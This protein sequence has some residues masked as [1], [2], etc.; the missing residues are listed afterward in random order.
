MVVGGY[1]IDLYFPQVNMGVECE[2]AYHK[3]QQAKDRARELDLID[4]LNA[5][6]P[7]YG[8]RVLRVDVSRGYMRTWSRR[9]G[10]PWGL[11]AP[12][13]LAAGLLASWSPG[14]RSERPRSFREAADISVADGV[15][16]ATIREACNTL[17]STG[18]EHDLRRCYFTPR[19]Q[20]REEYGD[21]YR[22]WFPAKVTPEGRG[23]GG[24]LNLVSLDGSELFE[25][26][27][28]RDYV[29]DGDESR[30]VVFI[31][32]KDPVLNQVGYRFLGVF[33]PGGTQGIEGKV[34]RRYRR[35]DER[36]PI[37]RA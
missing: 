25:G 1:F 36:F 12:R 14:S 8:Y 35:V 20:F 27:E 28:G 21:R 9:S 22:V 32:A 16:F 13:P 4:I 7:D 30:R 37:L 31:K 6:E 5:I 24:W 23:V 10:M 2:E 19:G 26:R 11:S 17:F 34:Y 18:Y 3:G 33:E 15:S 29:E